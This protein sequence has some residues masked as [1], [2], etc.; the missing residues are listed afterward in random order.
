MTSRVRWNQDI[1]LQSSRPLLKGLILMDGFFQMAGQHQQKIVLVVLRLNIWCLSQRQAQRYSRDNNQRYF[2]GL[3]IRPAFETTFIHNPLLRRDIA[4]LTKTA[5]VICMAKVFVHGINFSF[6][7]VQVISNVLAKVSPG[8]FI[9]RTK[10]FRG[11]EA[12]CWT[13]HSA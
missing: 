11:E 1:V 9:K 13:K 2:L 3:Y 4:C 10:P 6:I 12:E 7:G 5:S 8:D